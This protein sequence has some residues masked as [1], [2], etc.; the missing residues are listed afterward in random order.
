MN[1]RKEAFIYE[2]D[3]ASDRHVSDHARR[4]ANGFCGYERKMQDIMSRNSCHFL[5]IWKRRK[6]ISTSSSIIWLISIF[7]VPPGY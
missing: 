3:K 5:C 1:G 6:R 2:T 4:P 7:G